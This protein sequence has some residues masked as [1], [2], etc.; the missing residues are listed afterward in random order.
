M[1]DIYKK[2]LSAFNEYMHTAYTDSSPELIVITRR[3]GVKKRNEVIKRI[4]VVF[5]VKPGI[6]WP[7][8]HDGGLFLFRCQVLTVN[9]SP[10]LF[11]LD[12]QF[13]FLPSGLI[14]NFIA[15]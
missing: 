10:L 4:Y 9:L 13:P 5:P 1:I 11:F 3:N 15:V 14:S 12:L 6:A 7:P 8:F 2:A